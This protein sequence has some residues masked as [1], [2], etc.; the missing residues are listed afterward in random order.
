MPKQQLSSAPRVQS[1]RPSRST[2]LPSRA[3]TTMSARAWD[4]H[5]S[6]RKSAATQKAIS[7]RLRPRAKWK[8]MRSCDIGQ[9]I[10]RV[11]L[12]EVEG[13]FRVV[14]HD[15]ERLCLVLQ[16]SAQ[17]TLLY[18]TAP[19]GPQSLP[20]AYLGQN[21]GGLDTMAFVL[22]R[23]SPLLAACTSYMFFVDAMTS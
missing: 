5:Y 20:K 9:A 14:E 21:M 22:G 17:H 11:H 7:Q 2:V 13:P 15:L 12:A 10:S 1:P 3:S 4:R 8:R 6:G 23:P 19:C 18:H 16:R